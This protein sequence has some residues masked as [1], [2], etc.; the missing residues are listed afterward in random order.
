MG[1][2]RNHKRI[3]CHNFI[4]FKKAFDRVWHEAL[5]HTMRKH[6]IGEHMTKTI[7]N[8]YE[9]AKTKV[10]TG[11][12]FSHWFK[13]SVGVRQGCILTPTLFNMFLER[14]M[15]EATDD[16]DDAGISC[17]G[18]KVCNLH[19]A[20]DIDLLGNDEA[21][22]QELTI[23]LHNTSTR[24]GMEI[25]KDESKTMLSGSGEEEVKL[26]ISIGGE[27]LE[28]VKRCKYLG[29]T[30]TENG[31]S[32]QEIRNR[33][34]TATSAMVRLDAV[35]LERH[36]T[37]EPIEDHKAIAWETLLYGCE[38]WILNQK[39]VNKLQAFEMKSYRGMLR[40]K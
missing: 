17:G 28:Q 10:M 36:Q 11:D 19:F 16:L 24:F 35:E 33:I 21:E 8:L 39:S 20:D 27:V 3:I 26:E 2:T 25:S 4:D 7:K 38:S 31:P 12:E 9:D 22:L 6:S 29:A 1:E 15:I 34:G 18:L 5:W 40:I 23:R 13:A 32:E 37:E 14:I 30:I